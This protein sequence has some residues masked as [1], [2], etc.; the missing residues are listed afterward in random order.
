[1]AKDND[2]VLKALLDAVGDEHASADEEVLFAYARDTIS[3]LTGDFSPDY[4]VRPGNREEVQKVVRIAAENKIPL[5]TI[6]GGT[7]QFG[8]ALAT[9]GGIQIDIRRMN[10]IIEIS[11]DSMAATFEPAVRWR[12]LDSEANKKGLYLDLP[13]A[14]FSGTPVGSWLSWNVSIY[15]GFGLSDKVLSLEVVL[16]NGEILTTGSASYAPHETLNPYL[17]EA[18]GPD[19]TGLFRGSYG[20]FG[21]VTKV[22]MA[23]HPLYDVQTRLDIG[24]E[25]IESAVNTLKN[26]ARWNFQQFITMYNNAMM[27]KCCAP[28]LD[29]LEKDRKEYKRVSGFFPNYFISVG[30]NGMAKQVDLYQEMISD[31]VHKNGGNI[32]NPNNFEQQVKENMDDFLPGAGKRTIRMMAP[33]NKTIVPNGFIPLHRIASATHEVMAILEEMGYEDILSGKS[34]STMYTNP[35]TQHGRIAYLEFPL[36]YDPQRPENIKEVRSIAERCLALM[37]D[38]HGMSS[39]IY[40]PGYTP[41]LN[42]AYDALLKGIKR[43]FD[44]QE[45]MAPGK[46]VSGRKGYRLL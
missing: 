39:N 7:N 44:P 17:R 30:L 22:T 1:M 8:L 10:R 3:P 5:Y 16:P 6:N 26:I 31:L 18:Y 34:M 24:H 13:M 42:R 12:E 37:R 21:I 28:D 11:E 14:P 43:H 36:L 41:P 40:F 32:L 4:V 2:K 35:V 25:D 29:K 33:Y 45:I 46:L 23:L 9:S 38:K 27:T 15:M 19:L 20:A